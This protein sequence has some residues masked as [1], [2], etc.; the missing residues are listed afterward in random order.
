MFKAIVILAVVILLYYYFAAGAPP[1][2][3]PPEYSP[4]E[5]VPVA[6]VAQANSQVV[7]PV[8]APMVGPIA[9]A[10]Q[11]APVTTV[12]QADTAW[13]VITPPQQAGNTWAELNSVCTSK[14]KRLCNRGEMCKNNAPDGILQSMF[15][16]TAGVL[17]DNWFAVG[18]AQ[19]E[20]GTYNTAGNR[21]CKTHTEVAGSKPGWSGKEADKHFFRA[22]KCC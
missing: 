1:E 15:K 16:N 18:D 4:P 17:L 20:W 5:Y 11:V 19:N 2:Y 13:D 3:S 7:Q 10:T 6:N 8:T 12:T 22:A 9:A 14:G 21:T